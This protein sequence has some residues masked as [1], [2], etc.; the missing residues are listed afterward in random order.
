[1]LYLC[2]NFHRVCPF[3]GRS[4]VCKDKHATL[5]RSN[6]SKREKQKIVSP[7]Y[8]PK[9]MTFMYSLGSQTPKSWSFVGEGGMARQYRMTMARVA[10]ICGL[11]VIYTI[12][13]HEPKSEY[14]NPRFTH[15]A[16]LATKLLAGDQESFN[17]TM[18]KMAS[19]HFESRLHF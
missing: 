6:W 15:S 5:R 13:T 14:Q 17:S 1:M 8:F 12:R 2:R 7:F 4:I 19:L 9:V 3:R 10:C 11:L 16:I 18:K